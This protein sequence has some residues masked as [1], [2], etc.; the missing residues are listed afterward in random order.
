MGQPPE[1]RE[2]RDEDL[3]EDL[4]DFFAPLEDAGWPEGEEGDVPEGGSGPAPGPSG[5]GSATLEDWDV[6]IDV[7]GA[8]E[9]LA[10]G[11]GEEPDQPAVEAEEVEPAQ[12]GDEGVA[13]DEG[14]EDVPE[15][16]EAA[17]GEEPEGPLSVEDLRTAPSAY[18]D[19]PGP[20]DS[21]EGE[22]GDEAGV[23]EE[24]EEARPLLPEEVTA[25]DLFE[26]EPAEPVDIP[27]PAV[28]AGAK[29]PAE[30]APD[31]EA[32]EAAA[33]HF[34]TGVRET[35]DAVE[36]ELLADLEGEEEDGEAETVTVAPP[37]PSAEAPSWQEGAEAV[38]EEPVGA[39][40]VGRNLTAAVASGGLLAVAVLALL[41]IG[42]GAFAWFAGLVVLLGQAELYAVMRTRRLQP[43]TLLGLVCGA[44]ILAGSYLHGPGA[45]PFGLALAMGLTV[46]WYMAAPAPFRRSTTAN[47][48]ATILGTVYVPFLASFALLLLALPGDTGRNAFLVVVGLTV[49][50]DV[51]AYAVG[52]MWG[53]R[54][55]APTI[56]PNKSW[57]GVIGG[58]L[59][60]LLVAVSIIPAIDP[61]ESSTAVGL[62]LVIAL[63]APIGDLVESALKRDLGVKDMGT[64]L[65]GHGGIL[66]RIDAILFTAPAAYYFLLLVL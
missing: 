6:A 18:A 2:R 3:F 54:P 62:A 66:D 35:P 40:P 60:I 10:A 17:P 28:G 8:D 26:E 34:A 64:I 25:E 13:A 22:E 30:E 11:E 23:A 45:A 44:F 32:I 21:E 61:F 1:E 47:V 65:P 53:N 55:L 57:E 51:G 48:G 9:L 63:V 33:E 12:A 20:E 31:P 7:P 56:S 4:D 39:P 49:L 59:V 19:L 38:I 37:A 15:P 36:R 16:V 46:L 50:Y 52:S 5:E 41:L 43:A 24:P 42:K 14:T 27:E 58:T 29:A